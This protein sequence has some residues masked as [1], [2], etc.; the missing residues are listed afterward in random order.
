MRV[1]SLSRLL[2]VVHLWEGQSACLLEVP[3]LSWPRE[4]QL[5]IQ[6]S[7]SDP[8]LRRYALS[9]SWRAMFF[10]L[11]GMTALAGLAVFY[12]VPK[13]VRSKNRDKRVDWVGAAVITTS[14]VLLLF[15]LAQ[16]E[17]ASNQWKTGCEILHAW[18]L[19]LLLIFCSH[20]HHRPP[21]RVYPRD[22]LLYR[23][24]ALP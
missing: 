15:V 17:V 8:D 20:R 1:Q 10:I 14:L 12:V 3:S 6:A 16:G 7:L 18:R 4:S 21:Y 11:C 5:S 9:I 24:G 22:R 13:D 23:L 2:H 19:Y